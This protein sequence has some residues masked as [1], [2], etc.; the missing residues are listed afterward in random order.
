MKNIS[1]LIVGVCCSASVLMTGCID[2]TFPTNVATSEQL[3]SSSKATE[4]LLWAIP[5]YVNNYGTVSTSADARHYDFGYG[6]MIHIRDVMTEDMAIVSNSYDVW[7]RAWSNNQNLGEGFAY[8]QF[9]WN[10]YWKFVQ[11]SNNLISALNEE[12][13]NDMQKGYLGVAYAFRAMQYLDL[14]Q[15]FEFLEND[16]T[17]AQN[18]AGNNVLGLTVPIV[19]EGM[20]EA[21]ARNNPR[22]THEEMA[23]F[24]LE[25]LDKAEALIP[26]LKL[27]VKTL[28][29]LDAVYGLKARFY[30]W[31]KDYTKAKEYARKAIN[32]TNVSI[33]S[34]S[35]WLS[36]TKGF[37]DISAWMW[38]S[39]MQSEDDVVKT[40]IINWT[41][42]MSNEALY[43]YA[44]A[45]PACMINAALYDKMSNTDFRKL[46][47]KAPE[48]S[49]LEGQNA[50]I[51]QEVGDGLPAYASLKFRP[52][53]GNGDV[54]NIGSASAFPLMRVEEMYLIEAEAA[55]HLNA[56]DGKRLLE[57][58]MKTR[59]PKYVCTNPDV[60]DEVVLQKRIELWGE[61]LTFF[62]VKR[63]NMS[64]TRGYE[65]TNFSEA[66]RFN[67]N[68]R[69]AWMNFCI[70]RTEKNN[71][72]AL[73]GFE[74]PD[75]SGKYTPWI[76]K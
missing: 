38:G 45:G 25:D 40:G 35:A 68:G 20:T 42:W 29:H 9:V 14:A 13:A 31:E 70:V 26:N 24:I 43:G 41:S 27:T 17:K 1:K 72:T 61:G 18:D 64:V 62:D 48:G 47:W 63:L 75:P 11:T 49:A 8:P 10:Y 7:F 71:N 30:M 16:V 73:K 53:E 44:G 76:K 37:N 33:M 60:V 65:G 54:S 55:A 23:K 59:D 66:A 12:T 56:A 32:A 58:F 51:K 21:D 28:P 3:A 22:A 52:A 69:P 57:T 67:T 6:A 2:E 19:K 4:A 50:Y 15:Q 34:E 46:A 39:Q 5:A 74:N 36:T